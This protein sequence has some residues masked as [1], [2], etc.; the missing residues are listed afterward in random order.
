[1]GTKKCHSLKLGYSHLY[2]S[3]PNYECCINDT[4]TA[5]ENLR[6][7]LSLGHEILLKSDERESLN[8]KYIVQAGIKLSTA[9]TKG[10]REE[11]HSSLLFP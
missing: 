7:W 4:E 5:E 8:V 9:E 10:S 2:E 1:M 11:L 6:G 3:G